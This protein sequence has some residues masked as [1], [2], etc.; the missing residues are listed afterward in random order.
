MA[1][2]VPGSGQLQGLQLSAEASG[3][4]ETYLW[5]DGVVNE[6]SNGFRLTNATTG[7][8]KAEIRRWRPRLKGL[9]GKT[10]V[11]VGV[12]HG[13]D[14]ASTVERAHKLFQSLIDGNGGHLIWL[15]A[16]AERRDA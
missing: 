13:V 14:Q 5:T 6:P 9:S 12:G 3:V 4:S 16:L 7:Q 8:I 15:H 10:I 11:M 2:N 1:E